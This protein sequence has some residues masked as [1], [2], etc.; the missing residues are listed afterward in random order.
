M[1]DTS[2]LSRRLPLS[3]RLRTFFTS[4]GGAFLA[5]LVLVVICSLTNPT[6]SKP[7][8]LLNILRQC[9]YSGIIALGM[10]Y[11]IVAGGIDL[12]VGSLFALCGVATVGLLNLIPTTTAL[13]VPLL[14]FITCALSLVCGLLCGAAN[15][16]LVVLGRLP[17]FIATL[18]TYSIF[19]SLALYMADSGNATPA[20]SALSA[21]LIGFGSSYWLGLPT[22]AWI[23]LLLTVILGVHLAATP[24]GRHTLAAGANERVARFAGIRVGAVRFRT[25]LLI[26]TTHFTFVPEEL[27]SCEENRR[28]YYDYCFA[29]HTDE[30]VENHLTLN[31]AYLLFGIEHELYTFLCRTFANPTILHPLTPLCEYFF[32]HSRNGN[33]AK[34]YLHLREERCDLIV[35]KQG[36]LLLGNTFDFNTADDVAYFTLLAWKQLS[37]DQTRDRLYLA[38][39]KSLRQPLTALLQTYIKNVLPYPFPSQLF[40]LG[41]ETIDAPFEL[42]TIPLCGL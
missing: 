42:I 4:G 9:S 29:G 3:Q 23:L 10:T 37:L 34:A 30:V 14:V 8:N 32:L 1:S 6:F 15:G 16:A 26:D 24:L 5:L 20:S 2:E 18:G 28:P 11:V 38:G 25:Y 12:S 41:K 39:E 17:P 27:E 40:R 7:A 31:H 35:Y 13:P 19:R 21:S 33:E 22:P 36:R